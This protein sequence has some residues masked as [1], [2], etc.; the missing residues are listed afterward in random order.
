M[1]QKKKELSKH[2]LGEGGPKKD[3]FFAVYNNKHQ[4]VSFF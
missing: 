2:N 1:K 4:E 3:I